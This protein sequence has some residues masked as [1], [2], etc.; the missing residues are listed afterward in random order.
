MGNE[1]KEE[2]ETLSTSIRE[3]CLVSWKWNEMDAETQN[4]KE[5][6]VNLWKTETRFKSPGIN[7]KTWENNTCRHRQQILG[8][9]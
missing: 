7:I 4:Q 2:E 6:S 5:H 8:K 9:T 1:E 3:D